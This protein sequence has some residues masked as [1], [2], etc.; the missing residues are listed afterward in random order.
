MRVEGKV[1][2]VELLGGL[3]VGGV[4]QQDRAENGFFGIDVGGQAG[5]E[6]EIGMRGHIFE[7]RTLAGCAEWRLI[8]EIWK[9]AAKMAGP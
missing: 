5:V 1:F 3:G 2:G 9:T 8:F 7:C 4:V 6:G